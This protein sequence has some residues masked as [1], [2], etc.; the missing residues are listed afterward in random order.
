MANILTV[1]VEQLG[2]DAIV[3]VVSD[4]LIAQAITAGEPT[5]KEAIH[6]SEASIR[7]QAAGTGDNADELLTIQK[8]IKGELDQWILR[9]G[10]GI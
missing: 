5:V 1:I 8:S 10:N 7:R 6:L 2:A 4:A 3:P 9:V